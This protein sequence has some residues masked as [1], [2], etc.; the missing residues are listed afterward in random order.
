MWSRF[1]EL[2]HG[3]RRGRGSTLRNAGERELPMGARF[4]R[5]KL[6]GVLELS[7]R[8]AETAQT[9][10]RRL[11]SLEIPDPVQ[12]LNAP[13]AEYLRSCSPRPIIFVP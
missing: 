7:G 6:A 12:L 2:E 8:N 5:V 9:L 11:H 13:A 4:Y 10:P 3:H 1:Q